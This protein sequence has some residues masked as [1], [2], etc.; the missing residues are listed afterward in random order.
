LDIRDI[1]YKRMDRVRGR[2]KIRV[3]V[4]VGDR[5]R[6]EEDKKKSDSI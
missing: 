1:V 5:V 6:R 4:V 2:V 3:K